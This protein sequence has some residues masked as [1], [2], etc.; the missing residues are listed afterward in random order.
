MSA[1]S[2]NSEPWP[3][4]EYSFVL[5]QTGWQLMQS[6]R[7]ADACDPF[8]QSSILCPHFKTFELWG[9]CLLRMGRASEAVPPLAAATTLNHGVRAASLLADALLNA[10]LAADAQVA[11][12]E[13]LNRDPGNRLAQE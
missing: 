1:P 8:R 7:F 5:Y 11:A 2:E 3:G 13:A 9:E 6:R 12:R 4:D 10:G